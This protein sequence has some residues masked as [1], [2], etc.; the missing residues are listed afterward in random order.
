MY[1]RTYV[2][3]RTR[4]EEPISIPLSLKLCLPGI[5][6]WWEKEIKYKLEKMKKKDRTFRK[7]PCS[8]TY[9]AVLK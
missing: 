9:V 6:T 2:R 1:A 3:H 5:N 8:S 4:T 7:L